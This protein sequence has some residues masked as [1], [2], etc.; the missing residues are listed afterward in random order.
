MAYNNNRKNKSRYRRSA[1]YNYPTEHQFDP[2]SNSTHD[3]YYEDEFY[4]YSDDYDVNHPEDSRY[5]DYMY[6]QDY[7]FNDYGDSVV[8]IDSTREHPY[9]RRSTEYYQEDVPHTSAME[10]RY[11]PTYQRLYNRLENPRSARHINSDEMYAEGAGYADWDTIDMYGIAGKRRH[12]AMQRERNNGPYNY[13]Y[14]NTVPS[15][16]RNFE[17]ELHRNVPVTRR[18]LLPESYRKMHERDYPVPFRNRNESRRRKNTVSN[19]RLTQENQKPQRRGNIVYSNNDEDFLNAH[20]L[21]TVKRRP[22]DRHLTV[23]NKAGSG[24]ARYGSYS[25][26][27]TGIYDYD[28]TF[29]DDTQ[30]RRESQRGY[31]KA[32]KRSMRERD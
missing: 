17:D 11:S 25:E 27:K 20:D 1:A 16:R 21:F 13:G 28:T 23:E 31:G 18:S 14:E 4:D 6:D 7:E 2:E 3:Y 24:F 10:A 19:S 29:E 15:N 12:N 30:G 22:Q 32:G 5:D 9:R 8:H 26:G